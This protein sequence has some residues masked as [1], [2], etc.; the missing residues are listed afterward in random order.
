MNKLTASELKAETKN[1]TANETKAALALVTDCLK[2]ISGKRPAD[3]E[4]DRF[5]WVAPEV[6]LEAGWSRHEAAGTWSA[7]LE[8]D[9][10]F[11]FSD[12][13]DTWNFVLADWA[14]RWL[15]TI[16]ETEK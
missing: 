12:E 15:D 9:V 2:S 11:K 7:L 10:V 14:W 16:W 4:F 6:L 5:T 13:P 3:L 8:K 1:L